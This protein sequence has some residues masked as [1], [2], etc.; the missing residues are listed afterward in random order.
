MT[1]RLQVTRISVAA[2]SL[3][4]VAA[5]TG[6]GMMKPSSSAAPMSNMVA[7]S[8]QLRA[9]SE[10]PPNASPAT[11]TVDAVFNKDT[12]ML[13]WKVSYSGL[14]GPATAGHFH[15]PAA[16]GA[17]AGVVLPWSS[18]MVS[19]MEGSATLT[20]VQMADLMAGR[21]YANVHTAANPGGEVRGQMMV[22][23]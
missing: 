10:V 21:W 3:A 19:P 23:N 18:S 7:L 17:N 16:P 20:P 6:C 8:T 22:R 13:R 1:N 14:T 12:N 4:A 9:S 11:G 5:I 2:L 15:G